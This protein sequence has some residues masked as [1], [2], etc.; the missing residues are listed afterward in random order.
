MVAKKEDTLMDSAKR[1]GEDLTNAGRKVWLFGLGAVALV[2]DET[3]SA[4]KRLVTEGAKFEKSDRNVV[5]KAWDQASESARNL[6]R[7][8]EGG[9]HDTFVA[10]L[11]RAGIPTRD[12]IHALIDRVD[13]LA[14]KVDGMRATS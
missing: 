13:E 6:G 1:F 7:K 5:G 8:V 4:W 14:G 10:T 12:E 9:M 11:H 2:E 3:R